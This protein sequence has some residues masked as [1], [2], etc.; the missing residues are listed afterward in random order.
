M[1]VFGYNNFNLIN[2]SC[3]LCVLALRGHSIYLVGVLRRF[4]TV[5]VISQWE[6]GRAEETSTYSWSGFCTVN[7]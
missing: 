4:H 7:C 2:R 5:Q 6:V 3:V 1:V